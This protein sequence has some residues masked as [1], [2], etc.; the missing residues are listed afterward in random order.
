M[1]KR[2]IAIIVSVI[3]IFG[4]VMLI[5]GCN[6]ED[7]NT[8]VMNESTDANVETEES[9][10]EPSVEDKE[11]T[12]GEN[13]T[14]NTSSEKETEKRPEKESEATEAPTNKTENPTETITE[15]KNSDICENCG[16]IIVDNSD[17]D[18]P[19]VGNYCDGMCDEWLGEIEL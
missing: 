15:N 1:K 19:L 12:S 9:T 3:L 8:P 2:I 17:K 10:E 5:S 4:V 11:N 13:E 14:E 7:E 6:K 18:L 16:G